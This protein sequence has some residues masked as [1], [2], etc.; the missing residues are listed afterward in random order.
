MSM[1]TYFSMCTRNVCETKT[2]SNVL[3]FLEGKWLVHHLKI[4]PNIKLSRTNT[5]IN[6]PAL[7]RLKEIKTV[8][9]VRCVACVHRRSKIEMRRPLRCAVSYRC[10]HLTPC[11]AAIA[12]TVQGG[13]GPGRIRKYAPLNL[14]ACE[15][16]IH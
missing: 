15:L 4:V 8:P 11:C 7:F 2:T 3:C 5:P 6:G 16:L 13:R 12:G 1:Y 10:L 14:F 9:G